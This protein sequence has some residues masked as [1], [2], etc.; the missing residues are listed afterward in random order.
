[1]IKK[2]PILV[3]CFQFVVIAGNFELCND[4]LLK[5]ISLDS[6]ALNYDTSLNATG[7]FI[8]KSN[9]RNTNFK[10]K[11]GKGPL[12]FFATVD[13]ILNHFGMGD[14]L[15][16][17]IIRSFNLTVDGDVAEEYADKIAKYCNK[18]PLQFKK[19]ILKEGRKSRILDYFAFST[20]GEWQYSKFLKGKSALNDTIIIWEKRQIEIEKANQITH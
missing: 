4:Y 8:M 2:I 20:G 6:L 18:Y 19:A 14:S 3:C 16:Y 7:Q 12:E 9:L 1:M 13:S 11:V 17:P 15:L 10:T 5:I